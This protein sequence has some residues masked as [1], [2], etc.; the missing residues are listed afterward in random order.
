[1]A[2]P[3]VYD[4]QNDKIHLTKTFCSVIHQEK[5]KNLNAF[6]FQLCSQIA[7]PVSASLLDVAFT[8]NVY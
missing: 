1:M 5:Q 6:L 2:I 3:L 4:D 7:I 8:K